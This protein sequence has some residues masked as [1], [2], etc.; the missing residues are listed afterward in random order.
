[1][2]HRIICLT[3]VLVAAFCVSAA[4]E[5]HSPEQARSKARD[6]MEIVTMWRMMEELDLDKASA[7]KIFEI[8]RK[9]KAEKQEIRSG[10]RKD[11]R[12]LREKIRGASTETDDEELRLL[13]K[14]IRDRRVQ[15]QEMWSRQ[16]DEISATLT[17]RRQAKLM[18]FL[19][20]FRREIRAIT[21]PERRGRRW[22][23]NGGNPEAG[24]P[25]GPGP[26]SPDRAPGGPW[27]QSPG[28]DEER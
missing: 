18:L 17:V 11:L 20:D 28:V 9:Y 12:E 14:K 26:G 23:H 3:G 7:D 16:Y 13:L 21:R 2:T 22:R 27:R 8:R 1:M 6:R 4:A 24:P 25:R 19:K 5:S 15:L 10:L